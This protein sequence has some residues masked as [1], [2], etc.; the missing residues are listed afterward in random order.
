MPYPRD[1]RSRYV[2]GRTDLIL[3]LFKGFPVQFSHM[4]SKRIFSGSLST[5]LCA[6]IVATRGT[7]LISALTRELLILCL[8]DQVEH[9]VRVRVFPYAE[10]IQAVWVMFAVKYRSVL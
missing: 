9:A 3:N 4:N 8:G 7:S 2:L 6:E 1:T 5:P 10:S